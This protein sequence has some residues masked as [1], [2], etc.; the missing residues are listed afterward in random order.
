MT[1]PLNVTQSSAIIRKNSDLPE[2][3]GLVRNKVV[4]ENAT[5]YFYGNKVNVL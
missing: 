4:L 1:N 5:T 2:N 3:I